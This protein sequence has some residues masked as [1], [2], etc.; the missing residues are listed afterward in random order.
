MHQC[1]YFGII[2]IYNVGKAAVEPPAFVCLSHTPDGASKTVT[3]VGKGIVYDTGG[4]SIKG[5]VREKR[6][7]YSNISIP[8]SLI[9]SVSYYFSS[10]F[11]KKNVKTLF[12][13][14]LDCAL[15]LQ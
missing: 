9:N 5:K 12:M 14:Q 3:W 11:L 15:S 13:T 10:S 4:L 8:L 7:A 1:R 2:G 6:T